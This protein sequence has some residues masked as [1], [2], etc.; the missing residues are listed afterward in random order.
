MEEEETE[1][2]FF[3]A[4]ADVAPTIG[5]TAV[6]IK[7]RIECELDRTV[8]CKYI[9]FTT[10]PP[11]LLEDRKRPIFPKPTRVSYNYET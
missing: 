9:A 4:L 11:S 5:S 6:S 8:F 10:V 7:N 1:M 3:G 2:P